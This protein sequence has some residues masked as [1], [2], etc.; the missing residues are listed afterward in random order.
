MVINPIL[1]VYIPIIR[2]PIKGGMTIPTIAT[3]DHGT[4]EGKELHFGNSKEC[5]PSCLMEFVDTNKHISDT[6]ITLCFHQF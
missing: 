3:F 2:I 1:G 4:Y 6:L 5:N